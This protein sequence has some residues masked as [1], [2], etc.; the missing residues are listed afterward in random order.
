MH[1]IEYRR[2]GAR[3]DDIA[4]EELATFSAGTTDTGRTF[5]TAKCP[6]CVGTR[7]RDARTE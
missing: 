7:R 4:I 1:E 5:G 6:A 3:T 2:G